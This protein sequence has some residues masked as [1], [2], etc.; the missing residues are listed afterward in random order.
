MVTPRGQQALWHDSFEDALLDVVYAIGGPKEV[1]SSLWPALSP[2]DAARKLQ[3][4]L[5]PDRRERLAPNEVVWILR[6][7]AAAGCHVA[8]SYLTRECGYD[9]PRR[10][11][12]DDQ[13]AELQRQ[14]VE[15]VG[16]L[17]AIRRSLERLGRDD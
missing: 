12:P 9:T 13:R 17:E 6:A 1:A 2:L 15:G 11:S 14:F 7:G 8:M 10:V 5:A 4:C 16:Q 3:H